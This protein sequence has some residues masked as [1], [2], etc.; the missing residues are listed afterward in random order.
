MSE[1]TVVERDRLDG[2]RKWGGLGREWETDEVVVRQE[3]GFVA[4]SLLL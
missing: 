2:D 1:F 4:S 3:S